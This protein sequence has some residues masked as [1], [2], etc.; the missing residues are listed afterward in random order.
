MG[1]RGAPYY[2]T[3]RN[4]RAPSHM[5]HS[6]GFYVKGPSLR[7]ISYYYYF[8]KP[9]M[10][11]DNSQSWSFASFDSD[12]GVPLK[13]RAPPTT[14]SERV[15]PLVVPVSFGARVHRM[16]PCILVGNGCGRSGSL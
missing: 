7:R 1:G 3:T 8:I 2:C 4:R 14:T 5:Q 10:E 11:A 13:L 16:Q 6:S 15:T 12:E 9:L